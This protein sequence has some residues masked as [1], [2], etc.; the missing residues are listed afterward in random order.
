M[1]RASQ[2]ALL[3][4]VR[5]LVAA[6]TLV[7]LS[8]AELLHKFAADH[9]ETA[10]ATLVQRHGAMVLGVCRRM[11]GN[12]HDAEDA[13]QATFMVLARNAGARYWQASIGGW[14]YAVAYRVA[15]RIR[16]N[17][18]RLPLENRMSRRAA[19][20]PL[21]EITGRELLQF[22]DEE[23][24]RLPEKYRTPLVLC[25][26]QEATRDE[27]ARRL[28]CPLGTLKSRLERGRELLR[29]R[30]GA[31]GVT[32]PATMLAAA[33]SS[34]QIGSAVPGCLI[35]ASVRAALS[36]ASGNASIV[37][38]KAALLAQGV[39]KWFCGCEMANRGS[40]GACLRCIRGRSGV[41]GA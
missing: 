11:A 39:L 12:T 9:D 40:V 22:L 35:G 18:R 25:Y 5:K 24:Q 15:S 23:L 3:G 20:D 17:A 4:Q 31:R 14:L 21:S 27:A 7:R 16:V 6:G 32:L 36:F 38:T 2:S 19:T 13:F 10:F 34:E 28:G 33:L 1:A 41:G 30:L 29:R 8:D 26:L 37:S